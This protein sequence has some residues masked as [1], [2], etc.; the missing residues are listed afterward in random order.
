ML[1]SRDHLAPPT[2]TRPEIVGCR[3]W[4][5]VKRS[6]QVLLATDSCYSTVLF[7]V[8]F[9]ELFTVLFSIKHCIILCLAPF[10]VCCIIHFGW[11]SPW[12]TG[13]IST[14]GYV[15]IL[16]CRKKKEGTGDGRMILETHLILTHLKPGAT[17]C[18]GANVQTKTH[19]RTISLSP[20]APAHHRH[21]TGL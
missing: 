6:Y 4:V 2:P 16:Y 17:A 14:N 12:M 3:R 20:T 5:C 19:L 7:T 13:N 8:L 10:V 15:C 18:I 11:Y 1:P 21:T 9:A